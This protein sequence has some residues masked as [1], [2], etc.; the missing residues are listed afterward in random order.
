[1]NTAVLTDQLTQTPKSQLGD[2]HTAQDCRGTS[3][4]VIT[5]EL[6]WP[7][8]TGGHIRTYHLLRSLANRFDVRLIAGVEG[9]YD[10]G[11][12]E[13][14]D[15]G[16]DVRPAMVGARNKFG[17]AARVAKAALKS[18][19]YVMYRRHDRPAMRQ[20]IRA[21]I[22][23]R[24]PDVIYLDH[25]DPLAFADE[26]PATTIVADMHNVYSRLAERV[27]EERSEWYARKYLTREARLL[28]DMERKVAAT[29]DAVM[30]VSSQERRDFQQLGARSVHLVAN[31]VDCA[32]Y[33]HLPI[34]RADVA[35]R[36]LFLGALSWQPNVTAAC[37]LA[38]EA[39]PVILEQNPDVVLQIVGRNPVSE[40]LELQQL[41]G[42]QL[43]T[44]VPDVGVYLRDAALL[45]VPLDSGGGTR[46]KILEAFAAG[47]PVVSTPV[48]CE[49]IDAFDG[50]HLMIRSRD[51][52]AA[53]VLD[54]LTHREAAAATAKRA[55]K[56]ALETYDWKVIGKQACE[57]IDNLGQ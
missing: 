42:V 15:L 31:G 50:E 55:R 13:L 20:Q 17:E 28:A 16:I 40:V 1:M 52:F 18:E 39:L 56:L 5:S 27:A 47:L 9:A 43:A 30:T 36:I 11:L 53:G 34:G 14:R 19:P 37:F 44:N 29:A 12:D 54:S 35:P 38:R 24:K 21:E 57:V 8:N 2:R 26:F 48:G 6:P 46:L 7:L 51:E 41:P 45:A 49:G 32:A 22:A 23:R 33:S 3:I 10:T 4:L 25:L